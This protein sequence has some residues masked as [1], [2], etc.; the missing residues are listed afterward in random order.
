[1]NRLLLVLRELVKKFLLVENRLKTDNSSVH[2][3]AKDLCLILMGLLVEAYR[4]VLRT[5]RE[6]I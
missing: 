3:L 6:T 4:I 1:M 5:I 2:L